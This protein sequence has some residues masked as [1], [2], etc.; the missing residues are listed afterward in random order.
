M[1]LQNLILAAALLAI[2]VPRAARGD[3]IPPN[4]P[5]GSQYE[6]AFVTSGGT[7]AT[8]PDPYGTDYNAFVT[9]QAAE[10]PNLP[11]GVAWHAIASTLYDGDVRS[12]A[13]F[14]PSIPVYNT[15]GQLVANAATPL[16]SIYG[17]ILNPIG[18][19][20]FGNADSTLVW[21]GSDYDGTNDDP[22]GGQQ[23]ALGQPD[24]GYSSIAYEGWLGQYSFANATN[25]YPLYALSSPIT[26]PEPSTLAL[27]GV[28]MLAGVVYLRRRFTS[29]SRF[30][31]AFVAFLSIALPACADFIPPNLPAGSQYEIAFVTSGG[32]T[33]TDP[34]EADYN[35]FVT[36][37]AQENPNLPQT[38]WHA[39]AS[40]F[41]N[42]D[43]QD[44]RQNAPFTSS[45]P[46]Y[47]TAGQLV[48]NATTP[49]YSVSGTILNPIGYDQFGNAQNSYVWTGSGYDGTPD[50]PLGGQPYSYGQ[51]DLGYSDY[52][53]F[54]LGGSG[55]FANSTNVYPLFALSSPITVPEPSTIALLLMGLLAGVFFLRRCAAKVSTI[56]YL[57]LFAV[58]S[59]IALPAYADFIP[60]DLP[61]GSKYEIAF[62]TSGGTTATDP[63]EA[64]YNA[65]VTTQADENPNLPQGVTWHAIASTFENGDAQEACQ[66]A[67]FT[68]S[69]P[70]YNTQGQLVANAAV[71]LY[72]PSGIVINPI[73]Y[74]QF[75]NTDATYVWTGSGL[76]GTMDNALGNGT[77]W[78]PPDLGYNDFYYY[79]YPVGWTGWCGSYGMDAATNIHPL[80]AL[81]SP[82]TVPEPSTIALLLT[83]LLAGVVYLRR[84]VVK[85]STVSIIVV[86]AVL[87]FIALPAYADFIPPNLPAGSQY[88]IAFVTSGGTTATDTSTAD[89][90]AFVTQQAQQNPNLPQGVTWN[91]IATTLGTDFEEPD[92][93]QNAPFTSSIPVYNT[94]GQLVADAATPLYSV[95]G[96][97]LNPIEYDQFGNVQNTYVWTGSDYDGTPDDPLGGQQ[98]GLGEPDLGCS[99]YQFAWLGSSAGFANSTTVYPLFAL[100]SPITVPEPSTVVLLV[101]G[102][103][104]GVVCLRRRAV[105]ICRLSAIS[106][107]VVC[108][109][110]SFL[111]VPAL[112][113][114]IPPN[115]PPGRS[116][117]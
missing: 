46:V 68:S 31:L 22:L 79:G 110:L 111:S 99:S 66:N 56:S 36:A 86:C 77:F 58:L 89:Y 16:Y 112:A 15:Q 2:A 101:T 18:Y 29:L 12:N 82:I 39:M 37:Q 103:L 70:V 34:Y 1:K 83:G 75:G 50:D 108:A 43:I 100:S 35:A 21:T 113:G 24:L 69:I 51:P 45:I 80:Y 92:A 60:P 78:G 28:A 85:V 105:K 20:Q 9:A 48:A 115:L 26:V 41:E 106:F 8:D 117:R 116:T 17:N 114:F 67:P 40:T 23:Y 109:A 102:L 14:T 96:V 6:I 97:I 59:L 27:L 61:A 65:F 7:T 57:I 19:D 53:S 95:S 47:N 54:W 94:Q 13:P 32:T 64:D 44:P 93:R 11:Q 30:L 76:D 33:A 10:N 5:A 84:R 81:S 91:A 87:S 71:P 88:E 52:Q 3:F 62:V 107:L 98:Y 63:Y 4:L 25:V 90:N 73:L 38:T 74:D 72:S 42:G 104:A 49:L 55:G